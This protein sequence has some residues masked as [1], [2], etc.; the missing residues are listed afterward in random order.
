MQQ[1]ISTLIS[2]GFFHAMQY[3][4]FLV[5]S[6]KHKTLIIVL[7][8]IYFFCKNN[9]AIPYNSRHIFSAY[10][11]TII[12]IVQYSGKFSQLNL[13]ILVTLLVQRIRAILLLTDNTP[14]CTYLDSIGKMSKVFQ[15][16]MLN[17]LQAYF[18]AIKFLFLYV[19]HLLEQNYYSFRCFFRYLRQQQKVAG[20]CAVLF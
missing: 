18:K 1:V 8:N 20:K 19:Q 6:Y 4:E 13:V 3:C 14:I 17:Y 11:V 9:T 16:Q 5:T 10:G 15:T 2:F 7:G 12:F